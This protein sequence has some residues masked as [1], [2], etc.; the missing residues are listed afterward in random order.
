MPVHVHVHVQKSSSARWVPLTDPAG[1][2]TAVLADPFPSE[3]TFQYHLYHY[4]R[5]L[6]WSIFSSP[7]LFYAISHIAHVRIAY[8]MHASEMIL[9]AM[10]I[11]HVELY[12][13]FRDRLQTLIDCAY[14]QDG[15]FHDR[16]R[17]NNVAFTSAA[18]QGGPLTRFCAYTIIYSC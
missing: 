3:R 7:L 13:E 12:V 10:A 8:F 6:H 15:N 11:E 5:L 9:Y 16:W 17:Q 1:Q 14:E 2:C 4:R 18:I